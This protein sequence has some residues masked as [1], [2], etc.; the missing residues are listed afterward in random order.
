MSG[1]VDSSVAAALLAEAGCEV[2]GITMKLWNYA[3]VGGNVSND[4]RC[5]SAEAFNDARL[6][7]RK[8]DFPFYVIDFAEDF[9]RTVIDDFITE[10]RAGRTPNPCVLCNTRVKWSALQDCVHR[11]DAD[12]LATGHY[13]RIEHPDN[14]GRPHLLR[15]VDGSRDQSYFLWGLAPES[16]IRT[17]FPL[18]ELIKDDVR[19][20]AGELG[21][22]NAQRPESREICFVADNDYGRFLRETAQV[23]E[24]AGDIIDESGNPV[25]RHDGIAYYTIGQRKGIGA[26]GK[27][28]YVTALDP[29]TNTVHIGSEK[30][31][32]R[33]EFTVGDINWISI[34]PPTGPVSAQVKIRYRHP[35]AAAQIETIENGVRVVCDEPQ[36]A[37][38]PGQ[39]A[40][41]YD[42]DIVLGG[43]RIVQT[44]I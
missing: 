8:M 22:R 10:Y 9:H 24:T 43:G 14:S 33:R 37:I 26:H 11:L 34:D 17:I 41:F 18:G 5:C 39:S 20:I 23:A 21:L 15:G 13:A 2:I 16:L 31:L 35:P 29:E 42:G 12:Y 32:F 36:R 25:G 44:M 30:H 4:A 7:A 40:V 28:A 1:G 19:D 6:V 3:D 27:P 38:T